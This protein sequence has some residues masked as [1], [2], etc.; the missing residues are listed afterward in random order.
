M[1][2]LKAVLSLGT[3]S[4]KESII[5]I[6][7]EKQPLTAKEIHNSMKR[8]GKNGHTYQ[9]THKAIKEMV[10]QSVL[11]EADKKYSI[12]GKWVEGISEFGKS[13]RKTKTGNEEVVLDSLYEVDTF[14][15]DFVKE[16][17]PSTITTEKP[18]LGLHWNHLWVPLFLTNEVYATV[19]EMEP[20]FDMHSLS[21]GSTHLDKWCESFW[22]KIGMKVKTGA[23]ISDMVDLMIYNGY[24]L[25]VHYP[26]EIREELDRYYNKIKRIEELDADYLFKN[27]F[28]KKIK[29]PV[30]ITKNA[31]LANQ[32]E[33]ET[34][35]MFE[36]KK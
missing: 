21:K 6:L 27:V 31:A 1:N 29:I 16:H 19:K 35:A 30:T 26:K 15:L 10:G 11:V 34:R 24:V 7:A 25:E 33:M 17:P 5:Q 14:L 12:S 13:I 9:A 23:K 2:G 8:Q 22:K 32:M 36:A 18:F 20:L 3:S 28:L 4:S